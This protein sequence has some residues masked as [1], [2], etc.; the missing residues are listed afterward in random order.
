MSA[1][2]YG[3]RTLGSA[4]SGAGSLAF[5]VGQLIARI[6]TIV[7]VRVVSVE[8]AGSL[9]SCAYVTVQPLINQQTGNDQGVPHGKIGN[10]PVWRLQG[11]GN[12]VVCDPVAG[13]VGLMLVA[14]RDTS[15]L[16][17]SDEASPGSLQG[18]TQTYQP[19][20]AAQYDWGSGIYLGGVLNGAVTQYLLLNSSG[21]TVKASSIN[22]NGATIDSSGNITSPGTITGDSDVVGG[23]KSLKTHVHTG[24]TTGGGDTGPPL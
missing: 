22:L 7:P 17:A 1:I 23:G 5:V 19:G 13:D 10:V 8:N 2:S 24:V 16:V 20:N 11:G 4:L 9:T 21:L 18:G 3:Q 14:Y 12:A 15:A 6:I